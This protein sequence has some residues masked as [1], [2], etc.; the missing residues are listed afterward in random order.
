M[1]EHAPS[2]TVLFGV[3]D[4]HGEAGDLVSHF[5]SERLPARVFRNAHFG[6]NPAQAIREELDRLERTMLSDSSI[7][8]EFSGSTAVL[9]AVR[10]RR[11]SVW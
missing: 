11:I 10:D 3:L 6:T 8:T 7:D 1:H 2:G 5:V 9:A 4:G